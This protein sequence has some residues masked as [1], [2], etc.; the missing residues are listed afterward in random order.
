MPAANPLGTNTGMGSNSTL[1][2][3]QY[4]AQ[5]PTV[6]GSTNITVA[7]LVAGAL[8]VVLAFHLMG[9]RFAFD[10]SVGRR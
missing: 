6:G 7:G 5:S 2:S 10:V 8:V 1:G 9:F 4:N 3:S